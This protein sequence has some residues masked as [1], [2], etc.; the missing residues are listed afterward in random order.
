MGKLNIEVLVMR[1][2]LPRSQMPVQAHADVV[3]AVFW[4]E[5]SRRLIG[6]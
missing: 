4:F 3:P 5:W 6:V 2:C 1:C